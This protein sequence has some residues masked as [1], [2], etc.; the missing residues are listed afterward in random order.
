MKSE[1]ANF[2]PEKRP[3]AHLGP[4]NSLRQPR[5][6]SLP[7]PQGTQESDEGLETRVNLGSATGKKSSCSDFQLQLKSCFRKGVV[8]TR[9]PIAA[10]I[11]LPMAGPIG[12]TGDSPTLL[13]RSWPVSPS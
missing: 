2:D 11:A 1:D 8:L 7:V 4:S 3:A 9:F 6:C 12:P 5:K 13:K 10:K